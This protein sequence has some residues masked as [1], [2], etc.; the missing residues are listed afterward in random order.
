MDRTAEHQAMPRYDN[1]LIE[2]VRNHL[3]GYGLDPDWGGF[4]DRMALK[5]SAVLFLLTLCPINQSKGHEPCLLLSKRSRKVLQ[6]GDL[7]CPGGGVERHD[8]LL[9]HILHW[10]LS[11]LRKWPSWKKWKARDLRKANDLALFLTTALREGWEEMRLNPLKVIFLGPLQVQKLIMFDRRIYPQVGWIPPDLPLVPN[12]EIERLVRIPLRKLLDT[13]HYARYRL[14]FKTADGW[15]QRR[16]DMPCFIHRGR[17]GDDVLWGAT[18]RITMDFLRRIYG[19]ELPDLGDA[20]VI[21]RRLGE[22]YLNSSTL[23]PQD[24]IPVERINNSR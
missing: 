23:K 9:S 2:R 15:R 19:F 12:W 1:E 14:S 20:P 11:P 24:P 22:A 4:S 10:P 7:C 17:N 18:F 13:R 3:N 6:P 21:N 5:G 8:R 16:D